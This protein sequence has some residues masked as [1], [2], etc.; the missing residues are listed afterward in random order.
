[1]LEIFDMDKIY[2]LYG[3]GKYVPVRKR[4]KPLKP[5]ACKENCLKCKKEKIH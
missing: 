1:M 2:K 3:A 4:D 5:K